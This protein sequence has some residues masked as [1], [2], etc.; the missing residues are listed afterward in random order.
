MIFVRFLDDWSA[1]VDPVILY[2][3][4]WP[5][6]RDPND[7]MFVETAVIGRAKGL[8]ALNVA[9][10]KISNDRHRWGSGSVAY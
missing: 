3:P 5:S 4:Y 1:L 7:E 8:V 6:I 10:Y 2:F 9:D